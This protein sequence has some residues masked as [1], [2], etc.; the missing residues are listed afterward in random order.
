MPTHV[1]VVVFR[2]HSGG[3]GFHWFLEPGEADADFDAQVGDPA[4]R[5]VYRLQQVVKAPPAIEARVTAEIE[6]R[7]VAVGF[8]ITRLPLLR[9]HP[10]PEEN[11]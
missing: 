7:F 10:P 2:T 1:H 6:R 11:A 9:R 8:D 5:S 3:G 4:N